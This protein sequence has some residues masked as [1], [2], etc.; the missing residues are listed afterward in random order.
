MTNQRDMELISA[1]IDGE[2]DFDERV[3]LDLLLE[4]SE[5]ACELKAELEQLD[6]LLKDVPD[7]EPPV[8]LY[9]DIMARVKLKP[10][11]GEDSI[12]DWLRL[13]VPGAGLRYALAAAT[14]AMLVAVFIGSQSMLTETIDFADLVGTMA[15][16]IPSADAEIIDSYEVRVNGFES[17][18][19]LRRSGSALLLDIHAATDVPVNIS[20]DVSGAGLWPDALAQIEGRSESIAIAGQAV[21][22]EVLGTQR[23]TI[24]LRRV[25]DA[26][27]AGEANI[28]LEFSSEGKLLQRGSLTAT[29]KGVGQ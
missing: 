14:G 15:P 22:I 24:L 2:L 27:L 3:E 19:Q 7:L 25:D 10:A 18:V 23:L 13:L 12:V 8:S 17:L 29:L 1:A 4:T 16:D 20:V 11:P 6:S 21:H 26:A 9:A 5:E 28:T